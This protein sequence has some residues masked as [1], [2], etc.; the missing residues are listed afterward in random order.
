MKIIYVAFF[1]FKIYRRGYHRYP[2]NAM[3][4]ITDLVLV[5]KNGLIKQARK[6]A[7]MAKDYKTRLFY[8]FIFSENFS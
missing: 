6:Q 5:Y 3:F 8:S 2:N 4:C 7:V 1:D